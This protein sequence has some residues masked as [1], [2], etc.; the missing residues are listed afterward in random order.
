[1]FRSV[2]MSFTSDANSP[3]FSSIRLTLPSTREIIAIR[4]TNA[5][6]ATLII[7]PQTG[8]LTKDDKVAHPLESS[9][10]YGVY[11]Y[12]LCST[13]VHHHKPCR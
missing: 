8:E 5:A 12:G 1:M 10:D 4:P 2:F 3:I 6:P 11:L 7:A 9:S 13:A